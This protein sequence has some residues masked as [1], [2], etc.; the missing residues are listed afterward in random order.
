MNRTIEQ[1]ADSYKKKSSH[2]P[3]LSGPFQG[4]S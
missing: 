4:I 2:N 3:Q 1:I